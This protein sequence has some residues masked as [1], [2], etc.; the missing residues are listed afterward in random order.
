[1]FCTD[2][3]EDSNCHK[4]GL[5]HG[6]P[7]TILE[8]PEGCG[9]SR[10][11]VAKSMM[12]SKDPSIPHHL[13]KRLTG[14]GKPMVY[15]LT[16][17]YEF[18]RVP[19]GVGETHMRIDFSNQDN[20]WDNIVAAAAS[21]RKAKRSLSDFGGNHKRWLEEEWRDDYHGGMLNHEDL[22]KRWFGKDV[23]A[24]LT[25]L[26]TPEIKKEFTHNIKEQFIAKI[27]DD[28]VECGE[29]NTKVHAHILAQ[30]LTDVS[31]STSF[32]FTLITKLNFASEGSP[33]DLSQSYLTFMNEGKVTATFTLEA[34]IR[35]TY[36]SGEKTILT[37]PFPGASFRV[38]GIVT[39]GPSVR[40]AGEFNAALTLSAEIET[41]VD[42]ASWEVRQ[43]Y[44]AAEKDYEPKVVDDLDAGNTGD[45]NGLL[46]PQ[47]YAAVQAAGKAEAHLKVI[48]EFGI[49]F[50]DGWKVGA[51]TAGVV[52]DGYVRFDVGA[53][54]ST[55]ATCPWTYGLTL[56]AKLYAQVDT[57][58]QFGWGKKTW[59]LP[60]SGEVNV[61]PGGKCPDLRTGQPTKRSL[62]SESYNESLD[63][64]SYQEQSLSAVSPHR[65]RKRAVQWGPP[66]HV[67]LQNLLC[68]GAVKPV[69]DGSACASLSHVP[70]SGEGNTKV[71]KR[72]A[73][74]IPTHHQLEK[75]D[76]PKTGKFC[77][78]DALMV[79]KSLPF[80]SSG[81]LQAVGHLLQIVSSFP[82]YNADKQISG[83]S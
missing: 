62:L 61:I 23:I 82:V 31:I 71:A 49:R 67:D 13:V 30:A 53:G 22:H 81:D 58:Q 65:F 7:G 41:Q 56:G 64:P 76:K 40:V 78:G 45:Q 66:F 63:D 16:F 54:K 60:G 51:A 72:A 3:S 34:L 11:A 14:N 21:K 27:I 4:I 18:R 15:D 28:K 52:A 37:L 24:W 74:D 55:E 48:A 50:D 33:L 19:R 43:T 35:V 2:D 10:Y 12:P 25:N 80:P 39:I 1:M 9:A 79:I 59:D 36:E 83:C 32:G 26:V 5:G 69:K 6:V 20:Y 57:P 42:L 77:V 73:G 17:D 44:P 47:F 70:G 75:R 29:G 38:S 68:P 8:M 46:E